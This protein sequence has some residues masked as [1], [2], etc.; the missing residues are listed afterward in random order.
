[1]DKGRPRRWTAPARVEARRHDRP[2]L[3]NHAS[4]DLMVA[5][6]CSAW[7]WSDRPRTK[8]DKLVYMLDPSAAGIIAGDYALPRYS[9]SERVRLQW[10]IGCRPDEASRRRAAAGRRRTP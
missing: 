10:V 5:A 7:R 3:A 8:G 9:P 6:R 4:F 2:L 1:V